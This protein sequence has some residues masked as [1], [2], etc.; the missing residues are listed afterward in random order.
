LAETKKARVWENAKDR[1]VEL[2]AG[3]AQLK[4][5]HQ[6]V[7][8]TRGIGLMA[9]V[10]LVADRDTKA[11]ASKAAVAAAFDGAYE[12][13]VTIRV[14]GNN[15]ILSPP[16]IITATDVSRIVDAIDKGLSAAANV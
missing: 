2:Q 8:D 13:G 15:I 16:L 3:L 10:E 4:D 14:S 9:A 12:A 6:I 7:G 11:P 1:G 5:K